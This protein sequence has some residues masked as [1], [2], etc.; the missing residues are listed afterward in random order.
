MLRDWTTPELRKRFPQKKTLT[1]PECETT[2][3]QLGPKGGDAINVRCG[4]GHYWNVNIFGMQ[5]IQ[6]PC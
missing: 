4:E 1:C 6:G 3:F 2:A 5:A